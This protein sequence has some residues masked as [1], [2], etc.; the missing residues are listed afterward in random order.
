MPTTVLNRQEVQERILMDG[1]SAGETTTKE[2]DPEDSA[3][4]VL[5]PEL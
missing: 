5:T 4:K 3:D 2:K 1:T